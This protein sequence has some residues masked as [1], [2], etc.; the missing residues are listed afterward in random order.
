MDSGSLGDFVSTTLVDQLKLKADV[1]G[2]PLSVTMASSGSRTMGKHSCDVRMRYQGIDEER[3]FDVMNIANYDVIL[4]T[5]FLF[6]H[7]VVFGLDPPQIGIGSTRVRPISGKQVTTLSSLA[8]DLFED[9]IEKLRQEL[10]AYAADICVDA[11]RTPLPPLRAINHKIPLIDESKK[12]SYRPSKCPDPLK[13]VWRAT[14][15][16]YLETGRWRMQAGPNAVP[17]LMLRKPK[18]PGETGVRLRTVFDC[19]E[20]NLYKNRPGFVSDHIT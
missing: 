6:Q 5:P 3:R 20:R 1:L 19:R 8:V 17:M 11:S 14:K 4:G 12:Y 18:K 10:R 16:A 9:K 15:D 7:Q 2:K 13:E